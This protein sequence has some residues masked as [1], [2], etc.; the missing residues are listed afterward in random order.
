[1]I[2]T[3]AQGS[4]LTA[5]VGLVC[6]ATRR[7]EVEEHLEELV[8]LV[9]TAGGVVV[10]QSIQERRAPDPATVVGSGFIERLAERCEELKI[11]TVVFDEDLSGTQA[12]NLE[13]MLPENVKVLDRAAVILD[14]FAQRARSREAQTQV[15][16]A[17]LSYLLPRL[18]RRWQHLSRQAG[19]IGTRGVGETQLEIDRRLISK[20]IAQLKR[21][22]AVIERDR[23]LRRE[24]R[25]QHP[26]VALVGYTNAGKSSLFR[27]LTNVSV[28]VEDR[29]FATL[30]PRSRRVA[31]GD[32]I[33]AVITDTVGFIRKLPHDLV[34]PFRSTLEVAVEADIVLHLVDVSHSEWQSHLRVGDEVLD[35]LGVDPKRVLVVLN[36][37]DRLPA[38]R[39]VVP[40]QRRGG[41]ISAHTGEGID[42]LCA[43]VRKMILSAD[44]VMILKVPL[45]ESAAVERAVNLPHQIALR[46]RQQ[47]V[48][49]AVRTGSNRLSTSG[50][51]EFQISE[52][53]PEAETTRSG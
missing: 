23:R 32:E 41:Q 22:L 28:L 2:D 16:L 36:K 19:G 1:M 39:P 29:L 21:K 47:V 45:E 37:I 15:E 34:A 11:A 52:W 8:R 10:D 17:Q 44:D 50:L 35:N 38:G 3:Q 40:D 20:R 9:D 33:T 49:V 48:D 5:L 13:L 18:T 27:R 4:E 46:Y 6:S 42:E 14:I 24:R 31:F 30:D 25:Q 51:S 43:L 53:E 7:H 12:R 26:T